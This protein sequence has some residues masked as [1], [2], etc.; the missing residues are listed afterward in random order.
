MT[1]VQLQRLIESKASP[2]LQRMNLGLMAH[3]NATLAEVSKLTRKM[4]H[5]FLEDLSLST[6]RKT[7]KDS[8]LATSSSNL[9]L[10][11]QVYNE[12]SKL[13]V[14]VIFYFSKRSMLTV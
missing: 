2:S 14:L 11:R 7:N 6:V 13:F 8:Y 12:C 3:P 1:P 4:C 5:F 9:E 10:L